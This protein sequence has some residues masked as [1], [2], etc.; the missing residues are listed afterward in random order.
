MIDW[1]K[2]ELGVTVYDCYGQTEL[3]MVVCTYHAFSNPMKPGSMGRPMPGFGI[4]LIDERG[5]EVPSNTIGQ[6]AMNR[7]SP[8]YQFKG[9]WKEPEKAAAA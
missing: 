8:F 7:I 9:Y 2:R 6:I 4:G 5:N 3:L 1:F